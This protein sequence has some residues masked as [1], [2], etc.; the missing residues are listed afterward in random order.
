MKKKVFVLVFSFVFLF[1]LLS[2]FA[3]GSERDEIKPE[4]QKKRLGRALFLGMAHLTFNTVKYWI[5]YREW[6]EDWDYKLTWKDQ[7][8]RFFT[9][10]A[11]RFDSN[12]F[13][14]NLSH[15]LG[16]ELRYHFARSNRLNRLESFSYCLLLSLCWEY[17]SEFREV[18]SINDTLFSSLGALSF[19]EPLFQFG[20]YFHHKPGVF[21]KIV[22]TVFSPGIAIN[23]LLDGKKRHRRT[24][25]TGL[26]KP[27]FDL[28][29]GSKQV[30]TSEKKPSFRMFHMGIET[31]FNTIPGYGVPG[32]A[33]RFIKDTRLSEVRLDAT[34]GANSL[35]EFRFFTK[36]VLFGYF[37]RD[38][39]QI[40][41]ASA[42]GLR[43][44]GLFF[45]GGS[46]FDLF[47]KKALAYYDKGSYHYDL[48][49]GEKPPR[50]TRFTD[51]L[52]IIN[53]IG[54]VLD[55]SVYANRLRFNLSA[56]V[57][58]DFA[59]VHSMALNKY[60][61]RHDLF[62]PRM[63]TT[64]SYYG[65]Y[66]A[67]GFTL[68]IE[69]GMRYGNFEIHGKFKYQYYDSIEGLDRFQ[70]DV[71]D[72]CNVTD[73]RLVY[74]AALGYAFANTPIKIVFTCEGIDRKGSIKDIT[75]R[76]SEIRVYTQLKY[77]FQL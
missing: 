13:S 19:G 3:Y 42:G 8:R 46:G 47:K 15:V 40:K 35:E 71:A 67:L 72:D 31:R 38:I 10:Q 52:A 69:G 2:L 12:P 53:M 62:A 18:I 37:S 34:F 39:R 6:S 41:Q 73:Y 77:S 5:N 45:G 57:Y 32:S 58:A 20:D 28:Y 56:A 51:K 1:V 9:L 30:F 64:L 76:E 75:H 60:S 36:A 4:E 54:P 7:K 61:T 25:N 66:Y 48:K 49:G 68:A 50:P 74:K 23:T 65:Y 21:N 44:Y 59:L 27:S 16:G 63:K 24:A 26:S 70:R 14:I 29:F 22:G 33:K 17:F 11:H 43:G 55:L